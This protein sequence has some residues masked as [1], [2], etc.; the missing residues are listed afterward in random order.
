MW[1]SRAFSPAGK[2]DQWVSDVKARWTVMK[3]VLGIVYNGRKKSI[4]GEGH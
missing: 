4:P 1:P 3:R 2:A